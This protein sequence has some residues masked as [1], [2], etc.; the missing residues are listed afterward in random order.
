MD[1]SPIGV[2]GN[3]ALAIK[4]ASRIASAGHRAVLALLGGEPH[5]KKTPGIE[6][7]S[8]AT[9]VAFECA[10]IILA[11]EDSGELRRIVIGT[12][13]KIGI[14]AEMQPGG[15]L[16]DTGARPP[17][18]TQAL[19]GMVGM[20]G[21]SYVD[22]AL[23]GWTEHGPGYDALVLTGGYA[24]AVDAAE[25]TLSLFGKI[26]RTG[27]LGSAHTAAALMG[28]ME[29]AHSVAEAQAQSVGHALGLGPAVMG[30]II[31][32]PQPVRN[33]TKLAAHTAIV[34]KIALDRGLSADV[35]DFTWRKLGGEAAKSG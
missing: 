23:I 11:V 6:M 19:F 12:P 25:P 34:H 35:I 8:T 29:A 22:A 24:D 20:R 26:E 9:D 16:I 18:E 7:A 15:L 3:D 27:P 28:Y 14:G 21:I 17:R 5:P 33:V 4:L 2:I 30:H 31:E 10:T 32:L 1:R 13:D